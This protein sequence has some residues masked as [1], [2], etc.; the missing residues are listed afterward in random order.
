MLR[1]FAKINTFLTV[2][3][4]KSFSKASK[5][6]G[7][8][9]PAVTQQIKLL[10][11]YIKAPV[12]DR[13][14]NGIG[15]TK[16][17]KELYRIAQKL[18]RFLN[19]TEKEIMQIIDQ[20][21]TFVIGASNSIGKYIVPSFLG[22][23][24]EA[25]GNNVNIK[26][27]TSKQMIE[28]LE[29]GQVDIALVG[30]SNPSNNIM[31]REWIDDEVVLFSKAKLPPYL[32]KEEM[33]NYRWIFRE[34][35]S[36]AHQNIIR[37]MN[38]ANIDINSF[39]ISSIVNSTTA[40]KQTILRTPENPNKKPLIAFASKYAILDELE[41]EKL[42]ATRI[43]GVKLKRKLFAACLKEEKKDAFVDRAMN[44]IMHIHKSI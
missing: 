37:K 40:I 41:N 28:A 26:M 13:K 21:V 18:D 15:L 17:G 35:E 5:K 11:S 14:K 24:K 34:P 38:S 20:E 10:E 39:D 30:E 7:I 9:Q 43:R 22:D 4:E 36:D 23:I 8:S 19:T 32:K 27:G 33:A 31:F 3:K 6:L 42:Y 25:I 16:E 2:V 12:V 29:N 1:D 44:Y